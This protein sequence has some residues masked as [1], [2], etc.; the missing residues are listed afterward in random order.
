MSN[1]KPTTMDHYDNVTL[2]RALLTKCETL[3]VAIGDTAKAND[4]GGF[5]FRQVKELAEIGQEL[6]FDW[7]SKFDGMADD[8][9][10]HLPGVE[11]L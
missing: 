2:A 3:F 5:I 4:S 9:N 11:S 8:L 1:Q 10:K 6:A 7:S